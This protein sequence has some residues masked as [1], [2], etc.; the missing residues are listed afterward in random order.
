M[1]DYHMLHA[2]IAGRLIRLFT[3]NFL[4]NL[5]S[6]Y[7]RRKFPCLDPPKHMN[8][9]HSLDAGALIFHAIMINIRASPFAY[10]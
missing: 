3:E 2:M 8:A 9:L 6:H 5:C 1:I 4:D 10:F 7:P